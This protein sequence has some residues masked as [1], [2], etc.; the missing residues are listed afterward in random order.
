MDGLKRT[1][2]TVGQ[3]RVKRDRVTEGQGT[4][5]QRNRREISIQDF[6]C[7]FTQV[8]KFPF[9]VVLLLFGF[10]YFYLYK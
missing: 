8:I 6:Y 3:I 9:A 2:Q 10:F 7:I 1:R 5:Q 4:I